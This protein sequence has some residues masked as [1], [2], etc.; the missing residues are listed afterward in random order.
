MISGIQFSDGDGETI[1]LTTDCLTRNRSLPA[2]QYTEGT[3]AYLVRVLKFKYAGSSEL[4]G[5]AEQ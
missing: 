5:R 2:S 4:K 1:A 3:D